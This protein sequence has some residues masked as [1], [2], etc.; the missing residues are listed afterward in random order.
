MSAQIFYKNIGDYLSREEK[1]KI[2]GEMHDILNLEPQMEKLQPNEH[3]DWISQRSDAFSSFIPI[4]PEK[5]FDLNAKSFFIAYSL[6]IATN[7]DTWLYHF[8]I[9]E[10]E[11]NLKTMVSFYNEQRKDFYSQ[12]E[13]KNSKD[14]VEYDVKKINWTDLFLKDLEN[15]VNYEIDRNKFCNALYRPF[16]KQNFLYEKQFLQRTYQQTKIFPTKEHKNLVICVSGIGVTKDFSV[17]ITDKLPDIQLQANG[18]CFPL[19]WYEK[20]EN[21]AQGELFKKEDEY[22]CHSAI[23]NFILDQAKTRYGSKV[24]R[25][26]IFYYVYGML[27]NQDYRKTFANDLKKMLP[28]LPLVEDAKDFWSFS[29]AG[30]NLAELHLNYENQ[31]KPKGVKI[32][33]IESGNFIVSKMEFLDKNKK[34]AI[35]Y[36]SDIAISNIPA[37][38]YE[39]IVNGKSAIEWVMERYAVTTHKESGIKNNPNDWAIEH[40]DPR[41]ILNLLLS[42]ITVSVKTVEIVDGLP[43][44]R[45]KND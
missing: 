18:Q 17:I 12:N 32:S 11:K 8:S 35:K 14:F 36:N 24:T 19:Y 42:V 41:Y 15:N 9:K 13:I 2:V 3:G 29:K 38:A 39:Y 45:V 33:G 28:R 26:D 16:A 44:M 5:K 34:D 4:E 25:E 30:H 27:H 1:L 20:R 6:G 37:K 22:I 10:L 31:E 40:N 23:S 7:K 21:K 43:V